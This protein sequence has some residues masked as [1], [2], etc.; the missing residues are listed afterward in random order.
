MIRFSGFNTK[1]KS[2]HIP[3][4][5]KLMQ[6]VCLRQVCKQ[7][8]HQ[9]QGEQQKSSFNQRETDWKKAPSRQKP[10]RVSRS[11]AIDCWSCLRAAYEISWSQRV[12]LPVISLSDIYVSY[13][14]EFE[15][16]CKYQI[17]KSLK[18][19]VFP[20]RFTNNHIVLKWRQTT[21]LK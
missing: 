21:R 14:A 8:Q 7:Q 15:T 20:E 5:A 2:K 12:W 18:V 1:I 3:E 11:M 10:Q 6:S 17:E 4:F 19:P 16:R 13:I 9:Q